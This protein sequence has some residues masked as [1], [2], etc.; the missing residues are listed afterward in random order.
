MRFLFDQHQYYVKCIK[1]AS[2]EDISMI[3]L[4]CMSI[5]PII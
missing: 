3:V 1:I 2:L 5:Q 4:L